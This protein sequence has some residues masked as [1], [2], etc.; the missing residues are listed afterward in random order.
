MKKYQNLTYWKWKKNQGLFFSKKKFL[1]ALKSTYFGQIAQ[2]K[3]LVTQ[4]PPIIDVTKSLGHWRCQKYEE[5]RKWEA[6]S[7]KSGQKL[8]PYQW[9][10]SMVD[11]FCFFL[12]LLTYLVGTVPMSS[13][14][15]VRYNGF[16]L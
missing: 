3:G 13:F 12:K 8:L 9:K 6:L 1:E 2:L 7:R 5:I 10:S 4:I 11:F 16:S 15:N 14:G